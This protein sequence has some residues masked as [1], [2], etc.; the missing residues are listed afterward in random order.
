MFLTKKIIALENEDLIDIDDIDAIG[1]GYIESMGPDFDDGIALITSAWDTW[2]HGP[3]TS[4]EDIPIAKKDILN[5][6]S[7][8]LEEYV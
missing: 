3:M 1:G 2:K 8:L 6:L 4:D 5:Y 7:D